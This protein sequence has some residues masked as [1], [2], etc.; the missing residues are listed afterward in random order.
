MSRDVHQRGLVTRSSLAADLLAGGLQCDDVVLVHVGLSRLGYVCGA[1]QAVIEA[2]L[3]SVGANGSVMM[4]SFSGELSDPASWRVPPVPHDWLAPMRREMPP[5]DAVRTP[6]RQM[7]A[8]AE[9]FRHWPGALRSAHPHSSFSACGAKANDLVG[10]HPLAFRFGHKSPLA[11]LAALDGKVLLLGAGIDRASIIY[12]AQYLLGIGEP[13]TKS[14]PMSVAG[15]TEWV[16][17]DDFAVSNAHVVSGM[18]FLLSEKIAKEFSAG[19]SSS[20]AFSVREALVALADWAWADA[21][22]PPAVARRPTALPQDWTDWL[23]A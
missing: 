14:S 3:D 18:R 17:Y 4:P 9:L 15:R 8:V 13:V 19:D 21:D 12:L 1:A 11:K 20:I 6:S 5:F 7:G 23:Q 2:L 16:T 22:I 10:A